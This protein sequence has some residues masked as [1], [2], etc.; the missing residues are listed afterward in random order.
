[1]H[2]TEHPFELYGLKR[3]AYGL[4]EKGAG[5]VIA[6]GRSEFKSIVFLTRGIN[7]RGLATNPDL[8]VMFRYDQ[9]N[10][11]IFWRIQKLTI[12][13]DFAF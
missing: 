13:D 8:V 9:I 11:F 7:F 5:L 6:H 3:P 2:K 10:Y 1:L 12:N 4:S